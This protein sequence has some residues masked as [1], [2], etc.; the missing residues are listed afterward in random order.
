MNR[1]GVQSLP[2]KETTQ[3]ASDRAAVVG[4]D[5]S[6]RDFMQR[7]NNREIGSQGAFGL[8]QPHAGN[9]HRRNSFRRGNGGG[10]HPRGGGNG[11]YHNSY[12]S[13]RNQDHSNFEWN[14]YQNFSGKDIHMRHQRAGP[15]GFVR[16]APPAISPLPVRAYAAPMGFPGKL[17][18]L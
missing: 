10:P 6:P 18:F 3:S 17:H 11:S 7:N 1:E 4:V 16:Q 2:S 12:G 13:R 15:R 9:D 8:H 14:P 5:S